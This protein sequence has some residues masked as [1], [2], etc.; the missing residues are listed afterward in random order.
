[1]HHS[2]VRKHPPGDPLPLDFVAAGPSGLP[3]RVV[4]MR[5]TDG[6]APFDDPGYY[7]EPWWPGIRAFAFVARGQV[8]LRA[9][10]LTDPT[11]AFPE[12]AALPGLVTRDGV[13]LDVTLLV[14][15]ATTRPS[16]TFLNQRLDAPTSATRLP[17][18]AALVAQD[19][20]YL[21]GRS[22]ADRPFGERRAELAALMTPSAWCLPGRGFVGDG[23]AVGL[24]LAELGFRGVSARRLDAPLRPGPAGDAWYRV[25]VTPRQRDLPPFL[26]IFS[27]L[28]L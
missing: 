8:R 25:P 9:E 21:D 2:P 14:L 22:I 24:A 18:S 12:L 28:P 27:K 20:L 23:I 17:G 26:A 15:D 16:T 10:A 4:P 5:P 1:M 6:E 13:V 19:L 3:D 11:A 7:F